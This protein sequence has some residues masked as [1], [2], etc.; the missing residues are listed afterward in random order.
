MQEYVQVMEVVTNFF[1][2]FQKERLDEEETLLRNIFLRINSEK[3]VSTK[4]RNIFCK[5]DGSES[6]NIVSYQSVSAIDL[7]NKKTKY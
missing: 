2:N 3:I 4:T 5:T 1:E 6:R 7:A